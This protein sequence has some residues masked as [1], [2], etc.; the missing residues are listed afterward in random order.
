MPQMLRPLRTC[1]TKPSC[2]FL[3]H[4]DEPHLTPHHQ[5]TSTHIPLCWPCLPPFTPCQ[6]EEIRKLGMKERETALAQVWL[7]VGVGVGGVEG[8]GGRTS[9]G[10]PVASLLLAATAAT[11]WQRHDGPAAAAGAG[12]RALRRSA[13]LR[14][15][16]AHPYPHHPCGPLHYS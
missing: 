3:G 11:N 4:A 14:E 12:A 10:S 9:A 16:P 2:A 8:A 6:A 13:I 7:G 15:S 5:P 1:M